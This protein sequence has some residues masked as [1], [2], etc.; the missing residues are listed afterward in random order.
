MLNIRNVNNLTEWTIK[1]AAIP[2]AGDSTEP[3]IVS[4]IEKP[5]IKD[6]T[7][8]Y[9]INNSNIE[10]DVETENL[11][12][13]IALSL[14]YLSGYPIDEEEFNSLYNL[15]FYANVDNLDEVIKDNISTWIESNKVNTPLDTA[16]TSSGHN[17]EYYVEK[18]KDL[19][20]NS[21]EY[22]SS[23]LLDEII[24]GR[25]ELMKMY[26]NG[27]LAWILANHKQKYALSYEEQTDNEKSILYFYMASI[28]DTQKSLEFA[29]DSKAKMKRIKYLQA[30]YKDIAECSHINESICLRASIIYMSIQEALDELQI[31]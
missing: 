29:M 12:S 16:I 3:S 10:A 31:Y 18:E 19:Y 4:N 14:E 24:D 22:V 13:I 26:P 6:G 1:V 25:E 23:D 20:N 28:R 7:E 5:L 8:D 17:T 2:I 27:T 15:T 21:L 11:R 9:S 30:R